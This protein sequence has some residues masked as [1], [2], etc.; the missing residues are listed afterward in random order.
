MVTTSS[1]YNSAWRQHKGEILG[2]LEHHTWSVSEADD[3]L[4]EIFLKVLLQGKAFCELDNPRAWLFRV[5]RNLLIDRQ[6][7][8]KA[9]VP[10]LP[11]P[12][13]L[14]VESV[15]EVEPVDLLSHCLPSVLSKLSAKDREAILLCD[16]QGIAPNDYAKRLALSL[17]AAKSRLQRARLRL[18]SRLA[19]ACQV[20]YD[21]DGKVCCF[22]MR[23][24]QDATLEVGGG[25]FLHPI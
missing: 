13:D 17:P 14:S 8:T 10:L 20:S 5:A 11:L 9:Q 23:S 21:G 3:L 19:K 6:R 24:S 7:L 16:M 15:P 2:F 18:R 25:D 1:C 4:Q 22:V 12:D